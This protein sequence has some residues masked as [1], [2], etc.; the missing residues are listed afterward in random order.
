MREK[1]TGVRRNVQK[2]EQRRLNKKKRNKQRQQRKQ[3]QND[4]KQNDENQNAPTRI[5][6]RRQAKILDYGI[7]MSDEEDE[8][9]EKLT[10][11]VK[12]FVFCHCLIGIHYAP[13]RINGMNIVK[14]WPINILV[15]GNHIRMLKSDK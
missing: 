4:E 1:Y 9:P 7:G 10:F 3:A 15:R 5:Q 6:P 13:N 11:I 12:C 2:P 8:D 14:I